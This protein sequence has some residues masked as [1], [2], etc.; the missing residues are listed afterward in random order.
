MIQS[1]GFRNK[2]KIFRRVA[3][4]VTAWRRVPQTIEELVPL[5]GVGRK[6]ANVILGNVRIP[7]FPSIRM[8]ADYR[9]MGLTEHDD[10]VKVEADLMTLIPK[11][12]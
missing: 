9:R 12:D 7:A 5:G 2:A 1:T 6:T 8:S 11:D 10:P 3:A 4:I